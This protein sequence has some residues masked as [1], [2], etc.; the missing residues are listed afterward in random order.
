MNKNGH[1][2][3]KSNM[4]LNPNKERKSENYGVQSSEQ[5]WYNIR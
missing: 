1:S 2:N 5:M 4:N 3:E